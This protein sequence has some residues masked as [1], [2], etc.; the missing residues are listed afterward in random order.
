MVF[1]KKIMNKFRFITKSNEPQSVTFQ[2]EKEVIDFYRDKDFKLEF[3]SNGHDN[4]S[5][6]FEGRRIGPIIK[7]EIQ[8]SVKIQVNQLKTDVES[9][10]LLLFVKM[11]STTKNKLRTFLSYEVDHIP[12]NEKQF[13]GNMMGIPII[14]DDSL[15]DF[16]VTTFIKKHYTNKFK[17]I[18]G[19]KHELQKTSH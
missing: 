13:C 15:A 14:L 19:D 1:D 9:R 10:G 18:E 11:N 7:S 17:F 6:I 16:I 3:S 8:Q 12:K 2:K 5:I 4:S